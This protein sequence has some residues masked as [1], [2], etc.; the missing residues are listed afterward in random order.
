MSDI[1]LYFL[2]L[3]L[4]TSLIILY[5]FNLQIVCS[6]TILFLE[7]ILLYSFSSSD[8]SRF[9]FFLNGNDDICSGKS[10][11]TP[12]YPRSATLTTCLELE[13]DSLYKYHNHAF[14]LFYGLFYEL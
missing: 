11:S 2:N 4:N 9:L 6:I 7:W 13:D 8:R 14:F 3:F 10:F 5:F 1:L 12:K